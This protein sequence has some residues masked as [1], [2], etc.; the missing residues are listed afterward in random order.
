MWNTSTSQYADS[1]VDASITISI[2]Q[3]ST[4]P[5]G[6]SATVTNSGTNTDPIFNFGI[7]QG[8]TGA[9]GRGISSIAKTGTSGLVDTY[10]ITYSDG[11][12][13]NYTVTNGADG[14]GSVTSVNNIQPIGGNVTV[15]LEDC[16]V[17][18][19]AWNEITSI[20]S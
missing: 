2:G 8:T 5:A 1:G 14:E 6:S 18:Q 13:S 3:T 20:L 9:T 4:L 15:H 19:T 16:E 11:T 17:G 10:T 7:P 12:T